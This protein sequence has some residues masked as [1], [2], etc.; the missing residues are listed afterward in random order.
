MWPLLVARLASVTFFIGLAL[1]GRRPLGM[2]LRIAGLVMVGGAIDMLANALYMLA[3][4]VGPLSTV[5]TLSS[6]YP[7]STVL[8]ARVILGEG[9]NLV[10]VSGVGCALAAIVLIVSGG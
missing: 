2:P 3:A 5:V 7:A 4:Q 6:L 10:Q 1:A 9:L 8:L